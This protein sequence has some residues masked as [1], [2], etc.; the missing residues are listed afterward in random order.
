MTIEQ[1]RAAVEAA[2]TAFQEARTGYQAEQTRVA[3]ATAED[4]LVALRAAF[5]ASG[6]ALE[7]AATE[8]ERC[9]A[10]LAD[11]ERRQKL[12][13]DNPVVARASIP[14]VRTVEPPTYGPESGETHSFFADAYRYK[15]NADPVARERLERHGRQNVEAMQR[16]AEREGQRRRDIAARSGFEMPVDSYQFRDVGTGAFAGLTIP[17]YLVDLFAPYARA[18]APTLNMIARK[19]PLPEKGMTL[20]ISRATTGTAVA[21]QASENT[22]VQETDFDD[23]LLTIN[24]NTYAGQQDVSRQALER[25]EMVDAVIYQDLTMA[26]FTKLD[27]AIWNGAGSSGTHLGILA[28][29]GIIAV[30]YTDASPT[31]P[32]LYPKESDVIQ[33]INASVFAP[34][35][36]I[37]MAPRRWGWI[38]AALDSSNRPLVVPDASTAYNPIAV[39]DAASYGQVVG[40]WHGLPVV[41][42]GNLPLTNGAGTN[43]DVIGTVSGYNLLFWQEGDGMPRQLRFEQSNAPQSIRLAV[44]GYSAF[45]AGRYP[46]ASGKVSGTGLTA[47][48]F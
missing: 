46:A 34:A 6:T 24:V 37:V 18:G 31:V 4:D 47:P 14:G 42:D 19:L 8:L 33:Q 9:K 43:E 41:T 22:G 13:D 1:L 3:E 44:W 39:G 30:S 10:N 28:T 32:E 25:S 12:I 29:S 11:G 2:E 5:D 15:E 40:K 17:Q 45:S 27:D 16:S 48:T 20:N 21:A 26:Y 38:E 35:T 36:A 23:T 7:D